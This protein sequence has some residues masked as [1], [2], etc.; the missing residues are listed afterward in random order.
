MNIHSK[1]IYEALKNSINNNGRASFVVS[2]GSSPVKIFNDL[3]KSDLDWSKVSVT[4]VDDRVVS[5]EHS[6]SNE[7]LLKENLFINNA[8]AAKFISLKSDSEEV[9][10]INR[11]FDIMLLGMGED[12]HFAS[13]FP[14]LVDNSNYFDLSANPEIIF[15]EPMGNPCHKRVS[16][17]LSMIMKSKKIILLV[18][19]SAKSILVDQ[20]LENKY[21]PIHFLL[22]QQTKDIEII[23]TYT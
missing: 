16:M 9:M 12:G 23:K 4:L 7:K 8:S 15:T 10:N 20:A 11:P 1:T 3:S 18:S 19:S 13:L 17:N 2:G 6:D 22:N 14:E 21:L 5:S